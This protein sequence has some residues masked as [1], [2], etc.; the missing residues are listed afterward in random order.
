MTTA[1]MLSLQ[2]IRSENHVT[3][4]EL[5]EYLGIAQATVSGWE[6]GKST[7]SLKDA[8]SCAEY[9][10]CSLD[11]LVGRD[12]SYGVDWTLVRNYLNMTKKSRRILVG[13]AILLS[14]ADLEEGEGTV[15]DS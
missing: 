6:N 11:E 15:E 10:K 12:T 5:A 7:M 2:K 13:V 8:V 4:R 9:L 1:K 14:K 3:Q